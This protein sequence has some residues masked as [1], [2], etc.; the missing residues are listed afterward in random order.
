MTATE[1]RPADTMSLTEHLAELRVRI[2]RGGLAVVLGAIL[3][4]AFYEQVLTFLAAP[5]NDLCD[6]KDEAFCPPPDQRLNAFSPTEGF[7]AR[8]RIGM[9][10]GI[11]LALPVILWQIWRFVVPALEAKEKKYAI[12]FVL[13]SVVL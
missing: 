13:S 8:I 11:V 10:G 1:E 7:A 2:I 9:Y 12:P 3:I 5:Y 6:A 4:I